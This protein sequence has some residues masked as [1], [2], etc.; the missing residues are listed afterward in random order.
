MSVVVVGGGVARCAAAYT[1]RKLGHAVT[2]LEAEDH[3]GGRTWTLRQEGFAI[4][5]GAGYIATFYDRTLAL[6]RELGHEDSLVELKA[7]T[8]FWDGERLHLVRPDSPASYFK[9]SLLGWRDKVRL[10]ARSMVIAMRPAPAPF[11]TDGLAAAD[12]G[13]ATDA[14]ARR[15]LGEANYQY[16]IRP[17][18]ELSFGVGCEQIAAALEVALLKVGRTTRFLCLAEGMGA[19]CEWL[20]SDLEVRTAARVR[21]VE[22]A[23][24][25]VHVRG[26]D[27]LLLDADAAVIATEAPTAADLLVDTLD[28][29]LIEGLREAP[30]AANVHVALGYEQ[31]PWPDFP[32]GV[33]TPVGPGEHAVGSISLQA[34]KR[35]RSSPSAP[36]SSTSTSTTASPES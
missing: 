11:D 12:T 22:L 36:S 16:A 26:A 18:T 10:G 23:G 15:E 35:A 13:E 34:R 1:L 9:L 4:D 14:W 27:D 30:Y 17:M 3:V 25:R 20:V 24:E 29:E 33:V 5:T 19:L 21:A 8:G 2:L 32:A 7:P 6:V 28:R 31:D